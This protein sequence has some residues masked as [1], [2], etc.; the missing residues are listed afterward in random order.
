MAAAT[1]TTTTAAEADSSQHHNN[2]RK[3]TNPRNPLFLVGTTNDSS[4]GN[5]LI[6]V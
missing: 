4:K 5:A 6:Y 3:V 1:T 2:V